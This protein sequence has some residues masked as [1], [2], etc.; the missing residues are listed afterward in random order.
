ML[1]RNKIKILD[2]LP[3]IKDFKKVRKNRI[4][5]VKDG[6]GGLE[7]FIRKGIQYKSISCNKV[8]KN[9]KYILLKISKDVSF[10]C[11]FF[12]L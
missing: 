1:C 2:F 3:D 9:F 8:T 10:F 12:C 7:A 11:F 5:C 6:G 4:N